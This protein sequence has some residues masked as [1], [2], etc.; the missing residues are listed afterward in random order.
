M[1]PGSRH[2][3]RVV[4]RGSHV[5]HW[6]GDKKTVDVDLRSD[7]VKAALRSNV[8]KAKLITNPEMAFDRAEL[9]DSLLNAKMT[10]SPIVLQDHGTEVWFR[11]IK[12]RPVRED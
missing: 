5:T 12:I 11:N 2:T 7:T 10:P 6:L 1:T 8:E 4:V 3:S 9:A